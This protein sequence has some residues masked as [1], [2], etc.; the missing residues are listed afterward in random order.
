MGSD[1]L[2]GGNGNDSY[3]IDDTGDAVTELANEG[4]DSTF[5]SVSY[6]LSQNVENL[7][8]TGSGNTNATGNTQANILT[9]NTG[10]NILT[11]GFGNDMLDGGAGIDTAAYLVAR[12]AASVMHNADGTLT[13]DAGAD[14]IDTLSGIER[15]QFSD[16]MYTS[17]QFANPAGVLVSDFAVGA[18]GWV[19]QDVYPRHIADMNGDGYS[20]I[21]GFGHAGVLVSFGAADGSF[22]GASVVVSNFGQTAGWAS[23][24]QYHR[25][26]ADLNGDGRDDIIGFG[27][28]GTLVSLAKADGTFDN[29]FTG[30]SDF[31]E[32]QGW[33]SQDGF[34]RAVGD[35][36]GDGKA[37]IIGFGFAGTLVALGNGDGTFQGVTTAVAN[38]GVDQGWTSDNQFHRELADVNGDGFD[39]ILGFGYA[40]TWVGLSNGDGT[41]D[42]PFLGVADFGQNQ[43]WQSQDGFARA[44]GDINNDGYA[45][46]AGFGFAGTLIAYGNAN[47]AFSAAAVELDDFGVN[48]GWTSD[49]TFH[50]TIADINHDGLNDIVGFGQAGVLAGL[51]QDDLLI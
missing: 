49:T 32:F 46:I 33:A 25:E 3:Y 50:R 36:N 26:L 24:N 2:D 37:D 15:L 13:V 7:T 8:L 30:I 43:G 16:G 34:A 11:G 23:D 47:G 18:G 42:D 29:P 45:D 5:A 21:V 4:N 12:S 17:T 39:D 14:G 38:F 1:T 41:F 22:S 6:V 51:N 40:G 44:T 48:Q 27:I 31:G 9:G 35:V 28:A 19:S 10:D 20:D